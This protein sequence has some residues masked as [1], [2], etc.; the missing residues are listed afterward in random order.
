MIIDMHLNPIQMNLIHT[1]EKKKKTKQAYFCGELK[2]HKK[3]KQFLT[4]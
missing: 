4:A 3:K 2:F 1:V